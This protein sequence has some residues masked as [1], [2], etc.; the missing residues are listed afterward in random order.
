MFSQREEIGFPK[1]CV[2]LPPKA[3]GVGPVTGGSSKL[4]AATICPGAAN[5]GAGTAENASKRS[6]G[7]MGEGIA[8]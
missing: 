1:G 8:K 6:R 7:C 5:R 4:L 3:R 2:G